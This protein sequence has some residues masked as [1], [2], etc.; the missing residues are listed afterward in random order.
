MGFGVYLFLSHIVVTSNTSSLF[1]GH[2]G[3]L[4]VPFGLGLA[5]LFFSGKSVLGWLLTV[6]SIGG[7]LLAILGNLTLFFA[8]TG[9]LRTVGMVATMFIGFLMMVRSLRSS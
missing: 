5:L 2:A 4:I 9:L 7:V 1:Y 6:G 3:L 8:P